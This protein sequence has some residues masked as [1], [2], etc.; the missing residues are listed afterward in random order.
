MVVIYLG[1]KVKNHLQQIQESGNITSL[2]CILDLISKQTSFITVRKK[3]ALIV[4]IAKI[5]HRIQVL[6]I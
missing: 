5:H 2:L 4:T 3:Q 6:Y 1:K